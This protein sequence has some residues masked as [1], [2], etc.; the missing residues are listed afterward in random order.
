MTAPTLGS[1]VTCV[2]CGT[3]FRLQRRAQRFCSARCQKTGRRAELAAGAPRS[4]TLTPNTAVGGFSP[5]TASTIKDVQAEIARS[6]PMHLLGGGYRWPNATLVEP[7]LR[8]AIIHAELST[9]GAVSTL[10][11]R[12]A[13]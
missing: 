9:V 8:R 6:N 1:R 4:R 11:K 5:K 13:V 12:V 3:P 10:A 2:W 7:T